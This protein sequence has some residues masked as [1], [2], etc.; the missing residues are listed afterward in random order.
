MD[1][2]EAM[3][4][5]DQVMSAKYKEEDVYTINVLNRTTIF[6]IL[7]QTENGMAIQFFNRQ[8]MQQ[9]L[10]M[11]ATDLGKILVSRYAMRQSY[12]CPVENTLQEGS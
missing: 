7:F 2:L 5:R 4:L 11:Y 9:L 10:A 8:Q 3:R 12:A 6:P 1:M